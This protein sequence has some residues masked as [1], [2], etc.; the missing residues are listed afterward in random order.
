MTERC[1]VN[2][3]PITL[4]D[5]AGIRDTEEIVEREGVQRARAAAQTA[6]LVLVVIDRSRPLRDQDRTYIDAAGARRLIVINKVDL[7]AAWSIDD[8]TSIDGDGTGAGDGGSGG[9]GSSAIG[10]SI[11]ISVRT[12][13]GMDA[14][15][16]T[17]ATTLVG[18]ERL[19]DTVGV[20]NVRHIELLERVSE[21]VE[22]ARGG[23]TAGAP[24]EFV[25]ADIREAIEA[26]EEIT[27]KRSSEDVLQAIFS[28]FCIGK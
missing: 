2:G 12:G 16:E 20:S 3:I 4:V 15:R 19:R 11:D 14:L 22:R 6:D 26:L 18:D 23:A 27:G 21:A 17:I 7:P 5:T 25:L 10:P 8:L 28:R 13:S 24:E 9:D 1:D